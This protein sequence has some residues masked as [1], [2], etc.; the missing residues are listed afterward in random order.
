MLGT[1]VWHDIS[2]AIFL[3][4]CPTAYFVNEVILFSTTLWHR[5]RNK[6]SNQSH[7]HNGIVIFYCFPKTRRGRASPKMSLFTKHLW[8]L[9]VFKHQ[10]ILVSLK[11][12]AGQDWRSGKKKDLKKRWKI[13]RWL[14][15]G[16]MFA[17]V[18]NLIKRENLSGK[19]M[20][21]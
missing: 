2:A 3:N 16:S 21:H 11:K 14:N 1:A 10:K 20:F 13:T 18:Y 19:W 15:T 12:D 9:Q 5:S 8:T 4:V 7:K 6:R 17:G